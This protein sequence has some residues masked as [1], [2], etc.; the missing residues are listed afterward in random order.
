MI[1]TLLQDVRF[2]LRQLRRSMGFTAAVLLT[3][4]IGIGLNAAIFTMVDCVLLRPLGYH[5]AERIYS[6]NTRFVQEGR[7][8]PKMGGGDYVDVAHQVKGLEYTAYYQSYEDGLQLDGRSLYLP[9]AYV[10]PQFGQV[11]GVEPLVGRLFSNEPDGQEAMVSSAFARD[12]FGSTAGAV[13]KTLR[14]EGKVRVIVGVLPDGFSFPNKTIVWIEGTASPAVLNRT[15]YNQRVIGKARRDISEVVLNAELTAFSRQ[16]AASYPEDKLKALEAVPLQEQ[17]VGRIRPTLRLLMAS[18]GVVLLIVCG[19]VTHLQLVRA[20]RSRREISIRT[21]LGATRSSLARRAGAEVFLLAVMGCGAGVLLA[22]PALK[23]LVQMAPAD[24]PRL[25]EV[26]LNVEVIG[27]SFLLSLVTM[28]ITALFPLWRSWRVD[29][30]SAMKE[31]TARGTESRRSGRLRSLLV[32]GEVA[33]TLVLSVAAILLVRQFIAESQQD[34]GFSPQRLVALDTHTPGAPGPDGYARRVVALETMLESVRNIPG[35]QRAAAVRGAP[36]GSSNSNVGYAVRGVMEFKPGVAHMPD[37]NIIPMT[38]E[39]FETMGIPVVRGRGITA[40]DGA[41]SEKVLVIS[42][43]MVE[44]SFA[45]VDPI[46]KQIMC[47]FD[48]VTGW[49]TIVGVVGDVRQ[50]SPGVAPY[51]TL[52]VPVA[53]HPAV[54]S[55]VQV[56]VRTH[57]DAASMAA[58]LQNYF[59]KNYPAVAVSATTMSDNVSEAARPQRFRTMLFGSFAGISILLAMIGIYGVTAYTVSQ[60]RFE[61]ALRF[62]LGAK[63][64]QVLGVVLRG[65]LLVVTTGIIVGI[66][67]SLSLLRI[68]INLL[69]KLP[70]LDVISCTIAA[71][72]VLGITLVATLIP[73]YRAA[74]VDPMQTLRAE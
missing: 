22:V 3:L 40:G 74:H 38:P 35:V 17:L 13:G 8:I 6:L 64:S 33:L 68:V 25:G 69:G 31:D 30:A 7:S 23:L 47:G 16:L 73:A 52:Y 26:R 12:S 50:D 58:T 9:V 14:Y 59:K 19:N 55:D 42:K 28:S 70:T 54:A 43:S 53:Q 10:S 2:A 56:L 48:D 5:D 71:L 18:V 32:V 45:G 11:M 61:F 34:L 44:Q 41:N 1:G 20:T 46:G 57:S 37:A 65:A 24:I 27:F 60:R 39:Y 63:R 4:A 36:M 72:V 62:A 49:W 15:A 66:L 21:A 51:P 29:P 67:L